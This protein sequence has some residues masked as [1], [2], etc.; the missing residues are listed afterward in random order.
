MALLP[1]S[2]STSSNLPVTYSERK[3]VT[4]KET[5]E[6]RYMDEK[7]APK[8][9]ACEPERYNATTSDNVLPA[10][11]PDTASA[12]PGGTRRT[13]TSQDAAQ[14]GLSWYQRLK[15]AAK[16]LKREVLAV[17]YAMRHP[18]TPLA[19]KALGF[20]VL[21]Y[22]LSPL[23][24]I[25]D[26]IPVLGIL[27]DLILLPLMIAGAIALVPK[28][29]MEECRRRAVAE[30]LRL[31]RNW[32]AATCVAVIWVG[33]IE[34]VAWWLVMRYG[35]QEMRRWLPYGMAAGGTACACVFCV[36]LAVRVR[37]E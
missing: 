33:C 19:A 15:K 13:R 20:L 23:D 14:P 30:P 6:I 16:A 31:A 37:K 3:T 29:V 21:A 2:A 1:G 35:T 25:P 18:D 27:D 36:W 4:F 24:L 34:A 9:P 17:Y 7:V 12:T 11:A 26:F 28:P 22:A 32:V 10:S 5:P 8:E